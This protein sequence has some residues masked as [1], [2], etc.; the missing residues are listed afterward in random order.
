MNGAY[1]LGLLDGLIHLGEA[2]HLLLGAAALHDPDDRVRQR[3]KNLLRTAGT[4]AATRMLA[5]CPSED[6]DH[7]ESIRKEAARIER[8]ERAGEDLAPPYPAYLTLWMTEGLTLEPKLKQALWLKEKRG[9]RRSTPG[10]SSATDAQRPPRNRAMSTCSMN[11]RGSRHPGSRPRL[12][13]PRDP[14]LADF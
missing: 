9:R 6:A 14:P 10:S 11:S 2:G 12:R 7:P 1:R 8:R 13:L 4:K 3:A 5:R